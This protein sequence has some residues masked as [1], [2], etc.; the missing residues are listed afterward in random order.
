MSLRYAIQINE[1]PFLVLSH[2]QNRSRCFTV[3]SLVSFKSMV[4]RRGPNSEALQQVLSVAQL[5]RL[6]SMPHPGAHMTSHLS[7]H[8]ELPEP[9]FACCPDPLSSQLHI[10]LTGPCAQG[11]NNASFYS[12]LGPSPSAWWM[13]SPWRQASFFLFFRKGNKL[14]FNH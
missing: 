8:Q 4:Q 5:H 13:Q 14:R 11:L 3:F 10:Y 1:L 12:C 7:S 6:T 2:S 9:P